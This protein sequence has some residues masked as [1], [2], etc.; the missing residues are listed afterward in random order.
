M[1]HL[2]PLSLLQYEALR[3]YKAEG[4]LLEIDDAETAPDADTEEV[5]L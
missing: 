1:L 2:P 4:V 5:A 3:A